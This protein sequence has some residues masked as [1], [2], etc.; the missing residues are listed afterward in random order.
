MKQKIMF[1][2]VV[3]DAMGVIFSAKDDV[4]ELLIPFITQRGGASAEIVKQFYHSASIGRL[5]PDDFWN[6]VGLTPELE[7]EYLE[8]RPLNGC[9]CHFQI[10]V[11][12]PVLSL[13]RGN[14]ATEL[15]RFIIVC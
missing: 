14:V 12:R 2:A 1:D 13:F 11:Q 6:N 15:F 8:T 4:K 10:T 9:L 3:L 7:D 5:S